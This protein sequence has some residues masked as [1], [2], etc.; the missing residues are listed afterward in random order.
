MVSKTLV[1]AKN[2]DHSAG[3]R[4]PTVIEEIGVGVWPFGELIQY[5]CVVAV[6]DELHFTRAAHRLHLDQSAVSRHVQKLEAVLGVRLFKRGSRGVELTEAGAAFTPRARKALRNAR[7]AATVAKAIGR[8]EP[9]QFEIAYSSLVDV[10]AVAQVRGIIEKSMPQIAVKF[11]SVMSDELVERLWEGTA[12]AAV[13]I[14]P[15]GSDLTQQALFRENL[16]AALPTSLV[17]NNHRSIRLGRLADSAV[18]W[19]FGSPQS[20]VSKSI[21]DRFREVGYI[22]RICLEAHSACEA[23]ASVREGFGITF[24][25]ASDLHLRPK[26]VRF[27]RIADPSVHVETGLICV[28]EQKWDVLRRLLA[29]VVDGFIRPRPKSASPEPTCLAKSNMRAGGIKRSFVTDAPH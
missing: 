4:P 25:K 7:E 9:Q 10:H 19:P 20:A 22:P 15:A 13:A 18:V 5:C 29:V 14:L 26:G 21:L 3:G 2:A 1:I 28:P 23:L 11:R 24:V 16:Y 12:H 8:G 6:A 27:C 17:A